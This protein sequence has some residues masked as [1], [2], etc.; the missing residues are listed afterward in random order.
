MKKNVIIFFF[1]CI[2]FGLSAV[3]QVWEPVGDPAGISSG[4]VGRLSLINDYQDHLVV[5]YF[6][7]VSG[8]GAVQKYNGSNWQYLGS[9]TGMTSGYAIFNSLSVN[10]QGLVYFTNQAGWPDEGLEVRKYESNTW[11]DLPDATGEFINYQESA[12]SADDVLFVVSGENSGTIKKFVGGTWLQVGNSGFFGGS[13]SYLD[14]VIGSNGKIYIS[15]N[16]NGYVH[17]YENNVNA[18]STDIWQPVG[19]NVNLA[20]AANSEN[21]NSS[22]AIDGNNNLYIAYVSSGVNKLNVKKFNGTTWTQ[23]GSENF[24]ANRVQHIS[25]AVG[26]NDIVYVAVSNWEND[27]FLKNNILAYNETN[28]I[29]SQAGTGFASVGEAT[30]NSL[31]VDSEGNLFLAFMDSGLDK[32]SIKKLNLSIV[33]AQSVD[34]TT[35]GS[36]APEITV[37]NGTLQLIATVNPEQANQDVIWSIKTGSTFAIIDTNGLVT[38]IAS[39]TAITVQATSVEN[40]SIY[41]TLVVN[42]TNQNSSVNPESISVTT[43]NNTYPD[44]LTI[45]GT[46]QLEATITPPEADQYVTW[47]VVEGSNV[48]SVDTNGLVTSLSEGYAIIRA[49]VN[50][51]TSLFDEIRVNVWENGCTQGIPSMI[52]GFAY[53]ITANG[54]RGSDDFVVVT[55]SRFAASKVRLNII[56]SANVEITSFDL[57]FLADD[58]GH[59]G[60]EIT[61]VSNIIP[62]HQKFIHDWGYDQYQYEIELDLP[63]PLI[64][65]NGTYW[66]NPVATAEDNS[67]VYWDVTVYGSIGQSYHLDN[68]DGNG[69]RSLDGFDAAFEITGDCTPMPVVVNTTNGQDTTIFVGETLQLQAT[70]NV[71]GLSQNVIWSVESGSG[72]ASIDV[73]GLVNGLGV[74]VA[75][76]RATSA[77]NNSV[78]GEI[79]V[80]VLDPNGCI[81]EVPSNNLEDAYVLSGSVRLAVDI[82]VD[83]GTTFT[84]NSIE[85]NVVN[86]ATVFTFKFYNDVNGFPGSELITPLVN[87]TIVHDV[88]TGYKFDYYFHHYVVNLQ[89][90]VTLTAGS[91]WMEM[92]SNA[93]GWEATSVDLIGHP[94]VF[95]SGSTGGAWVYS[96]S[97]S[98]FVYKLNGICSNEVSIT[99]ND[100]HNINIFNANN[101]LNIDLGNSGLTGA[102]I[103][104]YNVIGQKMFTVKQ[105]DV[106]SK[107]DVSGFSS[108]IYIVNL[109]KGNESISKKFYVK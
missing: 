85:P 64:F 74:G 66:L 96:S 53:S 48:V 2:L 97:G 33:A 77:E 72:Y 62:T 40:A 108:G 41:D 100:L 98:E 83:N 15:F 93:V 80:T 13:P 1:T 32:L 24:T 70:I 35:Q 75:T 60:N 94:G 51:N 46:L 102:S 92:T 42:I 78:Y 14:M 89:T 106:M 38:A 28:N 109:V 31:E 71:P 18:S 44:I 19:G 43:L 61:S 7:G 101:E 12:F 69:W 21:Y 4:G 6:D 84:I 17:V 50:D 34:I 20:P 81:Q 103:S 63:E 86:F 79:K 47:T 76:I 27:N 26:E 37:N 88:V 9:E 104:V 52:F 8:K 23:L 99:N 36:V 58:N 59:L 49:T 67:D 22:L 68:Q 29:W 73:N 10:G 25:I 57:H 54:T 90:P 105:S 45:G 82:T 95:M 65:D 11:I 30:N 3:G 56:S 87:G 39:N 91:Y 55:G 16:N 5:G 107:Y